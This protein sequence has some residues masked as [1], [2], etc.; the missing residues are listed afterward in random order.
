MKKVSIGSSYGFRPGRTPHKALVELRVAITRQEVGWV[1]DAD[2]GSFFDAIDHR[3][4]TGPCHEDPFET[5][6]GH[7]DIVSA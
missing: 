6:T 5:G 7:M 2:S 3:W 4:S 1:F